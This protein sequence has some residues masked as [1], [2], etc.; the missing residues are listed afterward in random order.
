MDECGA[1]V[2][3]FTRVN[4]KRRW[5]RVNELARLRPEYGPV[6][7]YIAGSLAFLGRLDEARAVLE[8]A[9]S[10]LLDPRWQQRPPWLRPE[11]FAL[12][13][14]GLRLAAGETL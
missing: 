13:I 10:Q 4:S 9:G 5:R 11:D 6:H 8:R 7:G 1:R 14:E 3:S 12:R 2:Y